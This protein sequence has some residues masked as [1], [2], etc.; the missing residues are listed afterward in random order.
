MHSA[1][2]RRVRASISGHVTVRPVRLG[3][4]IEANPTDLLSAITTATGY[5]GGVTW[6]VIPYSGDIDTCC[7][8]AETADV[9]ALVALCPVESALEAARRD[10]FAWAGGHESP[11]LDDAF[12]RDTRPIELASLLRGVSDGA[13]CSQVVWAP[14]HPLASILACAYGYLGESPLPEE[15]QEIVRLASQVDLGA[16]GPLPLPLTPPHLLRCT[17]RD[18]R[19]SDRWSQSGFVVVDPESTDDLIAFWN[20]RA[21]G[22]AVLPWPLRNS[23]FVAGAAAD[24]IAQLASAAPREH[25]PWQVTVWARGRAVP[26]DL[27]ALLSAHDAA[28]GIA[29]MD[30]VRLIADSRW[31][32]ADTEHSRRFDLEL[33]DDA[34]S[35]RITLPSLPFAGGVQWYQRVGHVVADIHVSTQFRLPRGYRVTAPPVRW[36]A[37]ALA[38]MPGP[39]EPMVRPLVGGVAKAVDGSSEDLTLWFVSSEALVTRVMQRASLSPTPGNGRRLMARLIEMLGGLPAVDANQPAVRAVLDSASRSPYGKP[40]GAL[41]QEIRKS[42]SGWDLSVGFRGDDYAARVLSNLTHAGMLAPALRF[43]CLACGSANALPGDLVRDSLRCQLCREERPLAMYLAAR[44]KLV[45]HLTFPRHLSIEQLRETFPVMASIAVVQDRHNKLEAPHLVLSTQLMVGGM[46]CE[47]DFAAFTDI[48]GLPA[49][50]IGETKANR[51]EIDAEDVKHL[52]AVQSAIRAVGVDCYVLIAKLAHT[53]TTEET[54][55]IRSLCDGPLWHVT[56]PKGMS[57]LPV[58]PIVFL[59]DDLSVHT[60]DDRHPWRLARELPT[61]AALAEA[62]CRRNLGLTGWG[63][64]DRAPIWNSETSAPA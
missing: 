18:V 58:C 42:A 4:I 60:F 48:H 39:L 25:E 7:D 8:F 17:A 38:V 51:G 62:S 15:R 40:V 10:G 23:E 22:N 14:D 19:T 54:V 43:D 1:Y 24:L 52:K 53:L 27:Q 31:P 55:H 6:P 29:E 44:R 13:P 46:S 5:W 47:I 37:P 28:V 59:H 21:A 16:D 9:D 56:W 11:F 34:S 20:I 64:E 61:L 45:W 41:A 12:A 26:D 63:R 49:V 2:S 35:A 36:L 3:L 50:I 32:H 30:H 33:D 57:E